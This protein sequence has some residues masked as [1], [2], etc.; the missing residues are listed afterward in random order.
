MSLYITYNGEEGTIQVECSEYSNYYYIQLTPYIMRTTPVSDS[1]VV[2]YMCNEHGWYYE[3]DDYEEYLYC[4]EYVS[5]NNLDLDDSS[6]FYGGT[7]V[8]DWLDS[9]NP[10]RVN[11]S[12]RLT[13]KPSVTCRGYRNVVINKYKQKE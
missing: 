5:D 9:I 13:R 3:E 11:N 1:A 8:L 7:A 10:S 4:P 12:L 6:H 2:N